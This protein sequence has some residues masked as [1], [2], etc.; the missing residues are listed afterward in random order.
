M[1]E[2]VPKIDQKIIRN[3]VSFRCFFVYLLEITTWMN[4]AL[5]Y[6]CD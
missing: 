3:S 6:Q 1:C 5:L 4:Y 2:P